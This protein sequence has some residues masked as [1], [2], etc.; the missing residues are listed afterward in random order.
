MAVTLSDT[1]CVIDDLHK[2]LPLTG[3][4]AT[5]LMLDELAVS[6]I[7]VYELMFG[8][9][10]RGRAETES[11]LGRVDVLPLTARGA[12]LAAGRAAQLSSQGARLDT[13]DLLIA[14]VA[15][16]FGLALLTRNVRH[17]GRIEG[18]TLL[19]PA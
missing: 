16:D 10:D 6:A 15:L 1:D 14:G 4:F 17:F 11:F 9:Q 13:P 2:R 12:T 8:A 18:L 5:R 3:E 7:T 19:D